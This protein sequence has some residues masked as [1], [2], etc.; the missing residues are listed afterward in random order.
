MPESEHVPFG[1][2]KQREMI[3]SS[4][5]SKTKRVKSLS[6]K[7]L[8]AFLIGDEFIVI[9]VECWISFQMT[10]TCTLFEQCVEY[11]WCGRERNVVECYVNTVV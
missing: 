11:D 10:N 3:V 9:L 2:L 5:C 1:E 6:K 4:D 7:A 8:K